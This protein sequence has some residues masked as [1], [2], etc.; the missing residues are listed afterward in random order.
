M[1]LRKGVSLGGPIKTSKAY[2][3]GFEFT[4]KFLTKS[5]L[6]I[7]EELIKWI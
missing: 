1:P 5:F 3:F 2:I 7:I 4:G 6:G